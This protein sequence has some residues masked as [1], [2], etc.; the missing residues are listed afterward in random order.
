MV[1]EMIEKQVITENETYCKNMLE[2]IEKRESVL[3]R[4]ST[5]TRWDQYQKKWIT[6]PEL[7]EYTSERIKKKYKKMLQSNL[8]LLEQIA[9]T[10]MPKEITIYVNW[11]KNPYLGNNPHAEITDDK[12]RYFGSASGCGYD[13]RTA[14]IAEAANQS[15]QILK[16]LCDKKELELQKGKTDTNHNIIGY[17]SGY[18][19]IP[20]LEGGVGVSSFRNIFE[21]CGY[22]WNDYSGEKYD[23]Y[24]VTKSE[25]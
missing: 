16:I 21:N 18:S 17:G 20:K 11:V 2:A 14:A 12:K 8:E 25:V 13:K 24:I 19:A 5:L 6:R 23:M 1:Y 3:Q 15:L 22:K 10:E 9:T 4:E 7:V